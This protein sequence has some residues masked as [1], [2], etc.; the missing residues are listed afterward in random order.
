MTVLRRL[1]SRRTVLH[2]L[3]EVGPA[4]MTENSIEL[5]T[6]LSEPRVRAVLENLVDSGLVCRRDGH[7]GGFGALRVDRYLL[8]VHAER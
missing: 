8:A 3:S 6:A 2:A 4:G 5:T 7:R 1:R